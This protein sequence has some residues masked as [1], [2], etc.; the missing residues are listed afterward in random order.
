[1]GL[2]VKL[3]QTLL[4]SKTVGDPIK[5]CSTTLSAVYCY[6]GHYAVVPQ[7]L[8]QKEVGAHDFERFE[9]ASN[10]LDGIKAIIRDGGAFSLDI[11]ERSFWR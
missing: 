10:L 8:A 9:V 1:M 3:V 5:V 2:Q 11:V 4:D 6:G 7:T